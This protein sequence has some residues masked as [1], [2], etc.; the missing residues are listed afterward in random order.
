MYSISKYNTNNIN[1]AKSINFKFFDLALHMNRYLKAQGYKVSSDKKTWKYFLNLSGQKH[2]SNKEVL[3]T[4]IE[5]GVQKPLTK[6]ILDNYSY[7]RTELLKYENLYTNLI[8]TYPNELLYINGCITPVDIEKAI[9]AKDGVI[10]SYNKTLIEDNEYNLIPE[11][12]KYIQGFLNRWHIKEYSITD[13]LY[14]AS[15][16]SII[17]ANLP[18]KINNIRLNNIFTNKV[19]SFH[20]EN[21]F[22]SKLNILEEISNLN[23]KSKYWLYKNI[24][25]L[26][27]NVGQNQTLDNIINNILN[28]NQIG[29]G[30][31]KLRKP[32]NELINKPSTSESTYKITN[33]KLETQ[34]L[35]NYYSGTSNVLKEVDDIINLEIELN[36]NAEESIL[37]SNKLNLVK[38]D[39][40]NNIKDNQ[41]T[42]ILELTTYEIF[43]RY[44]VDL[45]KLVFDYWIHGIQNNM[46]NYTVEYIEPND[47]KTYTVQAKLGILILI[48][49]LLYLTSKE[50]EQIQYLE[51]H[52][53]LNMEKDIVK[54]ASSVLIK[55]GY[56]NALV[57]DLNKN[58]PIFI[59]NYTSNI[60]FKKQ[61]TN[62]INYLNYWWL[63]DANS[64][65]SYV[66]AN[67]KFLANLIT[68]KDKYK[69]TE[70]PD[71]IDNILSKENILFTYN[72][73]YDC[74]KSIT[75]IFKSFLNI[76]LN[77]NVIIENLNT[78][79]KS[80]LEKLTAYTTQIN[81]NNNNNNSLNIY[82][83]NA[84]ISIS[85]IGIL[86]LDKVKFIP[87]E[88]NYANLESLAFNNKDLFT[89]YVLNLNTVYDYSIKNEHM[90]GTGIIDNKEYEY[91]IEP[92]LEGYAYKKNNIGI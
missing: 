81:N 31:Y 35:N 64:N 47:N 66:S 72:K 8:N 75:S 61:I 37:K 57:E 23:N 21:Y 14:T 4:I 83:N 34:A 44:N 17:Y 42:K 79:F 38:N 56:S 49:V 89:N 29:L 10:L 67:L 54:K 77:E 80:I 88:L 73:N 18:N 53:V 43:K 69:I 19:H 5:L 3:V 87:L 45:F 28:E 2:P 84:N 41:N 86:S 7:T 12:Q 24:Q 11:L 65:N 26:I 82:Y 20:L 68:L 78:G 25:T 22:G 16:L 63:L 92:V 91:F 39:I 33:L 6:E 70:E 51:Y 13:E 85:N 71:T 1:L 46:F 48:K 62:I 60:Y 30:T 27:N 55:D 15:V 58:Y 40:K 50:N 52:T 59:N 32:N 90:T 36:N 74:V 76:E 9:E